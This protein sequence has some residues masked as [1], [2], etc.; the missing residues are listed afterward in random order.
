MCGRYASLIPPEAMKRI[1]KTRNAAP[2]FPPSWNVAPTHRVPVVHIDP[3]TGERHLGLFRWG[4][5]PVWAKDEKIGYST[6][7][8]R[9]ET[10]ASKPV[11][12]AAYQARRCL[13]PADA[14]YEWAATGPKTKQAYALARRDRATMAFAG[15][16]ES[17]TA[18]ASKE[19]I[20]SCTIVVSAAA[21]ALAQIHDR[22][23]VILDEQDWP[24]WLGESAGADPAALLRPYRAELLEAWA[25]NAGVGN[26]KN[27]DPGLLEPA[28]RRA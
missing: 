4:L 10:V 26:V 27:N 12:R 14:W 19:T 7:N 2:N 23:P 21:P 9:A 18:R 20:R 22:M 15:L 13:V 8:A 28:E 6:I 17:W 24:A 16:W 1:F 11:F 5:I 3:D 25:V